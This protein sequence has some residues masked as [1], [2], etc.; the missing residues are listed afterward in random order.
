MSTIGSIIK[1][2]F[3]Q[4]ITYDIN[5][6]ISMIKFDILTNMYCSIHKHNKSKLH[7]IMP[8]K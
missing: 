7:F 3:S 6:S 1:S 5:N 4:Q 8:Y 2:L